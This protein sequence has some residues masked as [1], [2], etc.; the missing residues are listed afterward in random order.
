M[1]QYT[2]LEQAKALAAQLA[3]IGGG[4]L[5]YNPNTE[6]DS[7]PPGQNDDPK[8]SGIYIPVYVTGPFPTPGDGDRKFYHFRFANGAEGFNA[9]L[10]AGT[11]AF[12]PTR[13]PVMIAAEVNAEARR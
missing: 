2:T 8:R 10:V 9:G 11:M 3:E 13:W 5:P 4:V 12:S 6:L 1:S 7:Y